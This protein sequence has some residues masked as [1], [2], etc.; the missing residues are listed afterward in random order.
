MCNFLLFL[1]DIIL[2]HH[3]ANPPNCFFRKRCF[4][5]C[6]EATCT[7]APTISRSKQHEILFQYLIPWLKYQL[8]GDCA[9]A[10]TFNN[11]ITTDT[12]VTFQKNCVLC[13]ASSLDDRGEIRLL[14][15]PNPFSES[16]HF[17]HARS[18]AKLL[19]FDS[20][21]K[22]HFEQEVIELREID[23]RDWPVGVYYFQLIS[24]GGELSRGKLIKI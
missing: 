11:S 5:G 1:S 22:M 18:Q 16:L 21:G 13:P 10:N 24:Q 4:Y 7:P 20:L 3:Y 8:K 9:A 14:P 17:D 19:I 15:M 2:Q 23:T 6:G 12:E